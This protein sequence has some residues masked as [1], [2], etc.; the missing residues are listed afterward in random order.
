MFDL[1]PWK[2]VQCCLG[3]ARNNILH[4]RLICIRRCAKLSRSALHLNIRKRNPFPP[5]RPRRL[6]PRLSTTLFYQAN[7]LALG[8]EEAAGITDFHAH[9]GNVKAKGA[10][11][12]VYSLPPSE[13]H[14]IFSLSLNRSNQFSSTL[15]LRSGI[16]PRDSQRNT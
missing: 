1:C 9:P 13:I 8:F 5:Y 2:N 15:L 6:T 4:A 10:C 7:G 14:N 16:R 3:N 11:R 12:A